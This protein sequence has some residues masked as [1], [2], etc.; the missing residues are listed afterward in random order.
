M[1][2]PA[3]TLSLAAALTAWGSAGLAASRRRPA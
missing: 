2:R 1:T 3:A